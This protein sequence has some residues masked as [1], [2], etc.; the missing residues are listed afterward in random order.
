MKWISIFIACLL[1]SGNVFCQQTKLNYNVFCFY[2]NWYGGVGENGLPNHWAHPVMKQHDS[3]SN[4]GQFPGNGNIG[5]N[6]YPELGEYNSADSIIVDQ[7]MRWIASAGIGVI[8]VTWLG[9]HDVTFASV[10][11]IL[12]SAN[13]YG[14][15][16]CFQIEPIVRK[17]ALTT[18]E[19]V[20]FL[21]ETF[22]KH[23]SFF[24]NSITN[25]PM[26]FVYDSYMIDAESWYDVFGEKGI[27]TIRNTKYDAD[28]IGLWVNKDEH[29]FFL[30]SGFDGFYTYFAS[31][32][33][34]YGSTP[35]NWKKLQD[36]ATTHHKLFIPSVGPGYIDSRIRP[37]NTS[38][39]K[40]RRNGTYYDNMFKIALKSKL[41]FIGITSFNEWHE[42]TQIEPAREFTFGEYH[43]ENYKPLMSNYYLE[44]TKYWL[45]KFH[46]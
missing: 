6:Y 24:R 8:A 37:W 3:D 42:G 5:A 32:G 45:S 19:A 12:N 10:P 40:Q 1:N 22:G 9:E 21:I 27:Q 30:N 25:K 38:N 16:V 7:H 41:K 14:I 11:V 34:T 15:K 17:T 20:C 46:R 33:F 39:T 2:Y 4:L 43:Y 44:R 23:P 18:K 26:F 31:E 35:T 28:M 29:Q 36:W 13:R